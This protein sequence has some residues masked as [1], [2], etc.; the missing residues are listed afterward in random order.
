MKKGKFIVLD[1]G[2][3]AGKTLQLNK[4]KE[5]FGDKIL[6]TREPGGSPYAEE[7]RKLILNS[8]NA[9]NADAKTLFALFW[10][11]RADHLDKTIKPALS[12][13]K[14]VI[15]DRFDSSTFSYQIV[16]QGARELES[17]FWQIRDVFLGECKPDLYIYMDLDPVVGLARK[18][19]Q[20][21]EEQNHFEAKKIDFHNL[22]R[23]GCKEFMKKV[24]HEVIDASKSIEEV[25][26]EFKRIIE[27]RI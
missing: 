9:K 8:E 27:S 23:E 18:S 26:E 4:A 11:A 10:A 20:G 21:V 24:P 17:L 7:I 2:E 5:Y 3:G 1:S 12:L 6:I 25:W 22:Q 16:A 13:G 15:T 19:G 14:T